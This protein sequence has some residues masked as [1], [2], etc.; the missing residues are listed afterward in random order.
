MTR[1]MIKAM[2]RRMG[3]TISRYNP[4]RDPRA[5]RRQWFDR[6]GIDILI[7]VGA[8]IGQYARGVRADGFQGRIISFEPLRAA[9]KILEANARQDG[10]WVAVNK[11][12]GDRSGSAEINVAGN[13]WSSSLLAMQPRHLDS[14]PESRYVAKER[15]ES[16]RCS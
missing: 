5:F 3:Y 10:N 11:A 9:F 1:D 16:A 14:A 8:N 13:S 6:F 7:D 15:L 4:L 12:I 2:A